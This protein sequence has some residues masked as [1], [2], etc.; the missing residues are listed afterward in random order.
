[1]PQFIWSQ[2]MR[3]SLPMK[4]SLKSHPI[5]RRFS[6]ILAGFYVRPVD[7]MTPRRP[8]EAALALMPGD[9]HTLA[10]LGQVH[11]GRQEYEVAEEVFRKAIEVS[12]PRAVILWVL[13]KYND[14]RENA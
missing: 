6:M 8:F 7:M 14:R 4:T 10:N 11:L 13:Q 1:M 2:W 12:D 3:R 5:S 9:Y